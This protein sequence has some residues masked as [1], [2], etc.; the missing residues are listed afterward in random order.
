MEKEREIKVVRNYSF[1]R[2]PIKWWKDR[3]AIA[4]LDLYVNKKW[5]E[6]MREEVFKANMD[7]MFYGG[8]IFDSKT[9]KNVPMKTFAPKPLSKESGE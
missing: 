9:M 5:E 4:L 1:W 6:G 8:A 7:M 2:H 3:K